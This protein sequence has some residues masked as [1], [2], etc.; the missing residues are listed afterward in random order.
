MVL[1][2]LWI[3]LLGLN[4]FLVS[5][6]L[7]CLQ[8]TTRC[9]PLKAQ[10]MTARQRSRRRCHDPTTFQEDCG[11][12]ESE[13]TWL[14]ALPQNV[15]LNPRKLPKP[16]NQLSRAPLP[17]TF[18]P[19]TSW[20]ADTPGGD[21]TQLLGL[22]DSAPSMASSLLP[23]TNRMILLGR[24]DR[25]MHEWSLFPVG[26]TGRVVSTPNRR[27]D[28]CSGRTNLPW[29]L[30]G[31]VLWTVPQEAL[32]GLD[33]EYI[34]S[35]LKTTLAKV[36]QPR[37]SRLEYLRRRC[38]LRRRQ[39]SFI[40]TSIIGVTF[41]QDAGRVDSAPGRLLS[42]AL[43]SAGIAIV[44]VLNGQVL[45]EGRVVSTPNRRLTQRTH[46]S[47]PS[48]LPSGSALW[49][50]HYK[51]AGRVDSV[52][53]RSLSSALCHETA[54]VV[55]PNGQVFT[56]GRVLPAS[57]RRHRRID[58]QSWC[59]SESCSAVAGHA[60]TS[61]FSR[62]QQI[63]S[64]GEMGS[65]PRSLDLTIILKDNS[66]RLITATTTTLPTEVHRELNMARKPLP[67]KAGPA[68]HPPRTAV[69]AP[70]GRIPGTPINLPVRRNSTIRPANTDLGT[71]AE[72][73]GLSQGSPDSLDRALD[74]ASD[75]D[76]D[77]AEFSAL[78]PS[79]S[80]DEADRRCPQH[81]EASSSQQVVQQATA[82]EHGA[83]TRLRSPLP[84]WSE[85]NDTLQDIWDGI[86]PHHATDDTRM[87]DEG[88]R[89]PRLAP[90]GAKGSSKRSRHVAKMLVRSGLRCH[91][92]FK[93]KHECEHR[94]AAIL[95]ANYR[96]F[97]CKSLLSLGPL[98]GF[99]FWSGSPGP[100]PWWLNLEPPY[101]RHSIL[102]TPGIFGHGYTCVRCEAGTGKVV[103]TPGG[104][105]PPPPA[106]YQCV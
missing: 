96:T 5:G 10:Q 63:P 26:G 57:Y 12:M 64:H 47:N 72:G 73:A 35:T 52:P 40:S 65:Q 19:W 1:D 62:W 55:L 16:D 11:S 25:H 83:E 86:H 74:E 50:I 14:A 94:K 46:H 85:A 101:S 44:I 82:D 87:Q 79:A 76:I 75:R 43:R 33:P 22:V 2:L 99:L 90:D 91:C 8:F 21:R 102:A 84:G 105:P 89:S 56:M 23:T 51:G 32:I 80:E 15:Q 41:D 48:W 61:K 78:W 31:P 45:M 71:V 27:V 13:S 24:I 29:L 103:S 53:G 37:P 28:Q 93:L 97:S 69:S 70:R 68:T 6:P 59:L 30:P 77:S 67:G 39:A 49:T 42:L 17:S 98:L 92:C 34:L 9:N 104:S 60:E 100:G 58:K 36:W 20:R 3:F 95:H 4:F 7:Q 38:L 54:T 88:L 18:L 66:A 106:F 81:S